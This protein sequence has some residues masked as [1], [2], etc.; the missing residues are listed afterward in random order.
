[1]N[2]ALPLAG[3]VGSAVGLASYQWLVGDWYTAVSLA[4]IYAGA[5]YFPLA[6]DI[7]P[8]AE[9]FRFDARADRVGYAVGLFGISTAPIAF[10]LQY[11]PGGDT[12]PLSFVV[13]ALGLVAFF[14]FAALAR[15]SLQRR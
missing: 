7:S 12:V 6:F 4:A 8:S 9:A 10:G 2:R 15:E 13:W 3:L 11:A 1:M 14:E 5:A